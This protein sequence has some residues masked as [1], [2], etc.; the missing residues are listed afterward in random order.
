[1]LLASSLKEGPVLDYE[2][3]PAEA[4]LAMHATQVV[5]QSTSPNLQRTKVNKVT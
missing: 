5:Q 2:G 1:M 3:R 4:L